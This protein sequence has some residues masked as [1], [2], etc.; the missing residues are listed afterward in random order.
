MNPWRYPRIGCMMGIE[1]VKDR[2]TK[3]P[4]ANSSRKYR[5]GAYKGLIIEGA[6]IFET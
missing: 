6:G 1:F 2:K 3:H 4:R 5:K